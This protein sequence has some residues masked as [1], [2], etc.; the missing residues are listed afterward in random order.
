[1]KYI[2][3]SGS[4][5]AGGAEKQLFNLID[6]FPSSDIVLFSFCI[7]DKYRRLLSS[8]PIDFYDLS[9]SNPGSFFFLLKFVSCLPSPSIIQGW[10]EKGNLVVLILN[11]FFPSKFSHV[12]LGHRSR[13][14]LNQSLVS[15]ILIRTVILFS[16]FK[17][18][19]ITHICNSSQSL[20][21]YKET[22]SRYSSYL[23]I[24]NGHLIPHSLSSEHYFRYK[25]TLPP[26]RLLVVSRYSPEKGLSQIISALKLCSF[27]RHITITFIGDNV[28]R[29]RSLLVNV[30]FTW[31]LLESVENLSDFYYSAHFL[32]HFPFS[33]SSSNVVKEA[34]LH[35]LPVISNVTGDTPSTVAD[36]GFISKSFSVYEYSELILQAYN[37]VKDYPLYEVLKTKAHCRSVDF[38][39]FSQM[40]RSYYD[41]Y[42][43]FSR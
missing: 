10:L 20:S 16:F 25:N 15:D 36:G 19:L 28:N 22:C 7:S 38:T 6:S 21:D 3:V 40:S 37:S 12:F 24:P 27:S 13:V 26:L 8:C 5:N 34:L 30:D 39:S 18:R 14:K 31:S 33:E 4:M 1:M 43:S 29:L 11:L 32:V 23:C 17:P 42:S 35:G 9:L 41:A 2:F